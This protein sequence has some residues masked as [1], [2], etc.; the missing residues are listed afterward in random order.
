MSRWIAKTPEY[1]KRAR[2]ESFKSAFAGPLVLFGILMSGVSLFS[3]ASRILGFSVPSLSETALEMYRAIAYP[4]VERPAQ[5]VGVTLHPIL[6]D[7]ISFYLLLGG[8]TSRPLKAI[9][10][11]ASDREE[12][13]NVFGAEFLKLGPK[14]DSYFAWCAERSDDRWLAWRRPLFAA[15]AI[16]V[17]PATIWLFLRKPH[18][19]NAGNITIYQAEANDAFDGCTVDFVIFDARLVLGFQLAASLLVATILSIVTAAR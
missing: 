12:G 2:R 1:D 17:V 5:L 6:K 7:S 9:F 16:P 10:D 15:G 13:G 14:L 11:H 18:T 8:I 3:L 4:V 19:M